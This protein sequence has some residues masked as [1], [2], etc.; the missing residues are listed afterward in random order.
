MAE[1]LGGAPRVRVRARDMKQQYI[2]ASKEKF[3]FS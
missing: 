3:L 1:F 2:D